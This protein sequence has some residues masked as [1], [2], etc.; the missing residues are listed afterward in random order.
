VQ[1]LS[2]RD[3]PPRDRLPF[4]HDFVSRN[5]IGLQF[6]P[7]TSGPPEMDLAT[8]PLAPDISVSQGFYTP[9][10]GARTRELLQDGKH[11]YFVTVH[12][13]DYEFSVE[14]RPRVKVAAGDLT[15]VSMGVLME[16]HLPETRVDVLHLAHDKLAPLVPGID[17]EP[18]YVV[19][20]GAHGA[21]LLVGYADLLRAIEPGTP[22]AAELAAKH[23]C[24]LTALVLDG[25]ADRERSGSSIRAA[26]L[27]LVK[28]DILQRLQQPGL[29]VDDVARR[30]GV[31]VRYIHKLFEAE[32]VSFSEYV[33]DCRVELAYRMLQT[34]PGERRISTVALD[35]GFGDIS[36]F[37]R[38]FR[39]RYGITPSELLAQSLKRRES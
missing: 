27:E 10:T 25:R 32:G 35:C 1:R 3:L 23:L 5:V 2:T 30:Q 31:S 34:S 11:N 21:E 24:E 6:T 19:P 9:L 38:A 26:R 13:D 17:L 39:Q 28:K 12:T 8:L 22:K 37:N 29:S 18:Y 36:N 33:R 4:V 14:G 7:K 16:F 15:I 20:A